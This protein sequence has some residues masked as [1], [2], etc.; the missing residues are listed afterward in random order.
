MS[1]QVQEV[2]FAQAGQTLILDAPEG[3]PSSVTSVTVWDGYADEDSTAELATTGA[4]AV[5]AN[6]NTTTTA[7]AGYGQSDPRKVTVTAATGIALG[8]S[9]LLTSSS[10]ES[11]WIEVVRLN[12]LDV[13]AR[14]KLHNTYP[15]GS[16]LATSRMSIGMDA[17]WIADKTNLAS[18]EGTE[19][20]YRVAWVYVVAGVTHRRLTFFDL[21]RN[22]SAHTVRPIDVDR[23]F[24]GWLDK[25]P[26]DYRRE[27]G[28]PLIEASF[29][30]LRADLLADGKTL[31]W[32]RHGDVINSLVIHRA[33]Q[34][35]VEQNAQEGRATVEQADQAQQLYR[36]RY[37]QLIREGHIPTAVNSGGGTVESRKSSI[38]SR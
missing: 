2:V 1:E 28:R 34:M 6:P 36:Q 35:A 26:T 33:N 12:G 17:A 8:R 25:L 4:G 5:E 3:R 15:V 27:Q 19:P 23:R 24:P 30:E 7:I 29:A 20:G 10:G 9:Y 16:A 37:D 22:S 21:V 11:E 18:E 38:W 31:R 32:L 14:A 13:Y